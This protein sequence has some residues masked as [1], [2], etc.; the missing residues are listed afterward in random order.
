MASRPTIRNAPATKSRVEQNQVSEYVE[1]ENWE[2]GTLLPKE[3]ISLENFV[4]LEYP[5]KV[6]KE[7]KS[8]K[9]KQESES[10]SE[11]ESQVQE[12]LLP[13]LGKLLPQK[14]K[15]VD[16]HAQNK[17]NLTVSPGTKKPYGLVDFTIL[18]RERKFNF[19]CFSPCLV[20]LEK[21]KK[22]SFRPLWPQDVIQGTRFISA[23][24]LAF[25]FSST[26]KICI[27]RSLSPDERHTLR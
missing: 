12:E 22:V 23:R 20:E 24:R 13:F 26:S 3:N 27:Q 19:Q 1:S 6:G 11:S 14:L 25:R 17:V 16:T 18:R 10:E 7:E 2:I 8:E 15:I 9:E 21:R 4:H 5:V